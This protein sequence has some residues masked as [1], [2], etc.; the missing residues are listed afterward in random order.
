ML[1]ATY[2]LNYALLQW[3]IVSGAVRP[4]YDI[5]SLNF[6]P[7]YLDRLV[8]TFTNAIYICQI[9]HQIYIVYKCFQFCTSYT[10]IQQYDHINNYKIIAKN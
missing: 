10:N 3:F 5:N 1:V 8:C 6:F 7:F 9:F 4:N 2:V